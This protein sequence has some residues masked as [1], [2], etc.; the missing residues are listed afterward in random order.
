MTIE[1]PAIEPIPFEVREHNFTVH[2]LQES[3]EVWQGEQQNF[4][5]TDGARS[6]WQ[7]PPGGGQSPTISAE[8][9]PKHRQ[10]RKRVDAKA[11]A[12]V[13]RARGGSG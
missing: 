10:E 7:P 13:A 11:H 12:Q 4:E 3:R 1:A 6:L 8:T 9:A 2:K 5:R